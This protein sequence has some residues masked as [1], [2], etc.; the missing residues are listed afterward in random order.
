MEYFPESSRWCPLCRESGSIP[1]R[2][3]GARN[4]YIPDGIGSG[5]CALPSFRRFESSCKHR[6]AR[7]YR[8]LAQWKRV[9]LITQRSQ[10][11]NLESRTGSTVTLFVNIQQIIKTLRLKI[12]RHCASQVR[13]LP[14]VYA[15][16]CKRSKQVCYY[17]DSN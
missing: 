9:A 2:N 7:E 15:L 5:E 16:V 14:R 1:D 12:F 11:R 8:D 6:G 13:I 3:W 17:V 4:A 10:D